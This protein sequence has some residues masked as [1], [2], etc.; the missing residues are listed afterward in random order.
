[1]SHRRSRVVCAALAAVVP[2]VVAACDGRPDR[3]M[4]MSDVAPAPRAG[5][6]S[7][8]VPAPGADPSAP[9]TWKVRRG[10]SLRSVAKRAYGDDRFWVEI[11][12]AN[13]RAVDAAGRLR[14]GAE[15]TL[16]ATVR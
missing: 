11:A 7:C 5:E 4:T 3:V 13:P 2:G 14:E 6:T 12:A 15:L 1:M 10:D 8:L 9:R 16:P